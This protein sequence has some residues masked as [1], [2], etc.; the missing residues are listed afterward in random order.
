MLTTH[1][2]ICHA[3]SGQAPRSGTT[4]NWRALRYGWLALTGLVLGGSPVIV[5]GQNSAGVGATAAVISS[6]AMTQDTQRVAIRVEGAGR[7]DVHAERIQNPERLALDFTGAQLKVQ[8][9]SIPGVSA[10]VRGVRMGQFRPDVARVVIDLTA[11]VPYQIAREG[12]AVVVYL[13]VQPGETSATPAVASTTNEKPENQIA[14]T[15]TTPPTNSASTSSNSSN[16]ASAQVTQPSV[17]LADKDVPTPSPGV[18]SV[19]NVAR[20]GAPMAAISGVAITQLARRMAVE[21][22]GAGHFEV[23]AI[24]IQNP[25][26]LALDFAGARL[27]TQRT[28]I[29]G[30]S[31]LVRGV[32]MGQFRPDVA[33]VV[34]DLTAP[35]PYQIAH[36]GDALVVYLEIPL[37]E[38]NATSAVASTESEKPAKQIAAVATTPPTNSVSTGNKNSN[39]AAAHM[40]LSNELTQP[41]ATSAITNAVAQPPPMENGGDFSRNPAKKLPTGAILV[42]GAWSSASDSVTPVPEG[43]SM[44]NNVY[45][46]PYFGLRYTLTPSWTQKYSSPPPSDSGYYVLAQIR[47]AETFEQMVRESIL[48]TAQ[49]LF[50]TL[51]SSTNAIK[52]VQEISDNLDPDYKVELPPTVVQLANHSFVRFDYGSS[53]ADLHWHILAIQIR[54][55][56]LE[57][58]S[59]SRDTKLLESII[60]GMNMIELPGA[61]STTGGTDEGNVPVCIKDYASG[62]NVIEKVDPILTERRFNS[63]PV[64]VIIDKEGKVRH[65]HFLSAFPDQT[66]AITDALLRWKFRPYLRNGQPVEVETGIMFGIPPRPVTLPDNALSE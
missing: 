65:I 49:D 13:Q 36:E 3:F 15:A 60:R 62:E 31:P 19:Q 45:N 20:A 29:P 8:R 56:A 48:I 47:P 35:T 7:L 27:E 21:V 17:P 32:R 57:F 10:P 38:T 44:N 14:G 16:A 30:V 54:C 12:D 63:V 4:T 61:A 5:R 51:P 39:P 34:I 46:N 37:A 52:L 42:K 25:E 18:G 28:S 1:S 50:F 58:I 43:G 6:V 41:S 53:V 9:T 11:S 23:Q 55:H 33:R 59:T 24:R 64:R 66:K 2:C 22:E 26:R 40:P